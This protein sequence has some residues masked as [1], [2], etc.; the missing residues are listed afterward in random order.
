MKETRIFR[1]SRHDTTPTGS[2]AN[3]HSLYPSFVA[4]AWDVCSAR[5]GRALWGVLKAW[6]MASSAIESLNIT[7][8]EDAVVVAGSVVGACADYPLLRS[9]ALNILGWAYRKLVGETGK[10]EHVEKAVE[11]QEEALNLCPPTHSYRG[12][13]LLNLADALHTR[14]RITANMDD[15]DRSISLK[16]QALAIDP[17]WNRSFYLNNLACSLHARFE[18]TSNLADL[19]RDIELREESLE[20]ASPSDRPIRLQGLATS[21]RT[22]FLNTA[23]FADL[24]R[25]VTSSEEAL[26]L[27][28]S[29]EDRRDCLSELGLSLWTRYQERRNVA[30]LNRAI[31]LEEETLKLCSPTHIDRTLYLANVATSLLSRFRLAKNAA[32]LNRAIDLREQALALLPPN[33]VHR[34]IHLSNLAWSYNDRFDLNDDLDDLDRSIT[35]REQALDACPPT[36]I[37]QQRYLIFLAYSLS[38]HF[39]RKSNIADLDRSINLAQSALESLPIHHTLYSYCLDILST[40]QLHHIRYRESNPNCGYS[41]FSIDH[42]IA[43]LR[44]AAHHPHS[45]SHH[46]L[47]ASLSW[48]DASTE[49]DRDSLFDAYTTTFDLLDTL[50]TRGHSL[51]SRYSQLTSDVWI[52]NAKGRISD[53][54]NFAIAQNRPHDAVVFLERG[55]A[56]LLAQ[57]GH[58]R[59]SLDI[60]REKDANL[61]EQLGTVGRQLDSLLTSN[62]KPSDVPPNAGADDPIAQSM[63]L[64][65]QWNALVDQTR[66][67]DGCGD[68]LRSTPFHTLQQAAVGGPVVFINITRSSSHAILVLTSGDPLVVPL[69]DATPRQV[70]TVTEALLDARDRQPSAYTLALRDLWDLIVGPVVDHLKLIVPIHSRIWWCP[71]ASV[72]ELPLHAAGHYYKG[73]DPNK[74]LPRLFVSSYTSSLGALIRARSATSRHSSLEPRLL[75][76]SQPSTKGEIELNVRDEI[77]FISRKLSVTQVL[78]G[79][80]GT[81]DAVISA[82]PHHSWVHFSCHAYSVSDNP[83]RSHFKLHDGHLEVLDIL[84]TQNP[85]AELAVLTACHTAGAGTDAPEEF[86]HLAGAMQFTGFRSVIGTLW[87]MDDGDG[88]FVVMELYRRLFEELDRGNRLAYTCAAEALQ[89]TVWKLRRERKTEPWRWVNYVHYGA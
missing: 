29:T 67:L 51:E 31:T 69:L 14:F 43:Q 46:R 61:A 83:L 50:I 53:A 7:R 84:R 20:L 88:S 63:R 89:D 49:F 47:N 22:R 42:V 36:H 73:A 23:N 15:L 40:A 27:S 16:E 34:S 30:D 71:S 54:V 4:R 32:D 37:D 6:R 87:K 26:M 57:V 82:V 52:T 41:T 18:A 39:N 55:R 2:A 79:P 19:D 77:S 17:R 78:E 60:V 81:P 12:P 5:K 65:A 45:P 80:R 64:T 35:L 10:M 85:N 76:V 59:M 56:L 68:F 9:M 48:I 1:F 86:L 66:R 38:R 75:V 8:L 70:D 33:H 25:A 72:A 24:E 74:R 28:K 62:A 13:C 3:D 11:A 21:L 58:C 44:K